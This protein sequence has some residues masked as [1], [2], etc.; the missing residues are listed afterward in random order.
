MWMYQIKGR[1]SYT[2]IPVIYVDTAILMG[3]QSYTHIPTIY[4][5]IAAHRYTQWYK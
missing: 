2:H 3:R 1:H 5:E 4:V